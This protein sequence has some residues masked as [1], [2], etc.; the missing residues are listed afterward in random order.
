MHP[1][2]EMLCE[3]PFCLLFLQ[4]GVRTSGKGQVVHNMNYIIWKTSLNTN[5]TT[6][7]NFLSFSFVLWF[8]INVHNKWQTLFGGK[9]GFNLFTTKI[10]E[11][12][13]PKRD[14][15]DD[16]TLSSFDKRKYTDLVFMLQSKWQEIW[17]SRLMISLYLPNVYF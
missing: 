2:K 8:G 1:V 6:I 7:F 9:E 17:R 15:I 3:D 11:S 4:S 12:N 10:I 14:A 5:N 16:L 13:L